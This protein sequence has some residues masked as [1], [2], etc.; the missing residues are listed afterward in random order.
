MRDSRKLFRLLK[1]IN[2]IHF[3]RDFIVGEKFSGKQV[4]DVILLLLI[5]LGF[6]LYWVFDNLL[7]LTKLGFIQKGTK[8]FSRPAMFCWWVA[9]VCSLISNLKKLN[10]L[11]G[12]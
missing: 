1:S 6:C 3:F 4:G 8:T 2:E 7:I 11:M 5:K 10:H 12:Q 9:N